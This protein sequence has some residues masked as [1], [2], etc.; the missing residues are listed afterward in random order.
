M[1][2]NLKE[3]VSKH[4]SVKNFKESKFPKQWHYAGKLQ[5]LTAHLR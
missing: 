1:N 3:T 2:N 4:P 5:L